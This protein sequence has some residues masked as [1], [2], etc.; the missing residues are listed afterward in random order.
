MAHKQFGRIDYLVNNAGRSYVRACSSS[1]S[2]TALRCG[3][4]RGGTHAPLLPTAVCRQRGLIEAT[5]LSVDR[6][7]FE[8]NVFGVISLTKAV[9]PYFI[10]QRG[11]HYVNTSSVAGK[12]GSPCSATYAAT[13]HA[14]QGYFDTVRM[15]CAEHNVLVTNVCPGP[16][17]SEITMHAF[18]A[19]AGEKYG[20][21]TE[22]AVQRMTAE[23]CGELMAG[24]MWARLPEIWVGPQPILAYTYIAQY[25]PSLYFA[26]GPNAGRKRV[27]AFRAGQQGYDSIQ[28]P[29]SIFSSSS[30]SAAPAPVASAAPA[31]AAAAP[32]ADAPEPAPAAPE[33]APVVPEAEA[34][35]PPPSSGMRNRS[36]KLS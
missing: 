36:T 23:R 32:A 35:H 15:E 9:L 20:K 28:N 1:G 22:D 25:W 8:L 24:A 11:G 12:V 31:A 30:K 16:V 2:P 34:A 5:P 26:V 3:V 10:T 6:E 19:T 4:P 14:I 21:P 7:L 29:L 18:T 17:R 33:P 27:A 13:K